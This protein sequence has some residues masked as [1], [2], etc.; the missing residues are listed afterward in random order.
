[1]L[2][3]TV[4]LFF[5]PCDTQV[6]HQYFLRRFLVLPV[7]GWDLMDGKT[8]GFIHR[9]RRPPLLGGTW[10]QFQFG[11]KCFSP[12]LKLGGEFPGF[13]FPTVDPH[14]F[15]SSALCYCSSHLKPSPLSYH[16]CH[17][18]DYGYLWCLFPVS[19]LSIHWGWSHH[20]LFSGVPVTVTTLAT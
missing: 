4:G 2:N 20:Y 9:G 11:T 5:F 7:A 15:A 8:C 6:T 19:C 3:V 14:R 16:L 10:F 13:S 18:H 1:M 12:G 17:G